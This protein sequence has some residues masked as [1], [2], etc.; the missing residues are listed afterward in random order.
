M[1][2]KK[3]T[4]V[5]L[6]SAAT[7]LLSGCAPHP[8][9][10]QTPAAPMPSVLLRSSQ[11]AARAQKQVS[12][13][14][15]VQ[16]HPAVIAVAPSHAL[17]VDD[18]FNFHWEGPLSSVGQNLAMAMGWN[19]TEQGPRPAVMPQIYV[20]QHNVDVRWMVEAIN[21]QA[22]PTAMLK[23]EPGHRSIVLTV[24]TPAEVQAWE[25][26]GSC[27]EHHPLRSV[28]MKKLP[29]PLPN[30]QVTH[31]LP[32]HPQSVSWKSRQVTPQTV[33]LTLQNGHVAPM[34]MLPKG[35]NIPLQT[36]LT[37]HWKLVLPQHPT[38]AET[39]VANEWRKAGGLLFRS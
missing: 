10:H 23:A 35:T 13:V 30:G 5:V 19:F 25:K 2:V 29:K 18:R 8:V 16:S 14:L 24:P 22:M 9:L 1:F 21:K 27:T 15:F 11:I 38:A 3:R 28:P 31:P 32:V 4:V 39:A 12:Q 17:A 20:D 6:G 26:T 34:P 33:V 37:H 7:A 36:A